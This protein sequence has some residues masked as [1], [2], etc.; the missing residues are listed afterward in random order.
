MKKTCVKRKNKTNNYVKYMNWSVVTGCKTEG[1]SDFLDHFD[2]SVA[3]LKLVGDW[4]WITIMQ[5][6]I[7]SGMVFAERSSEN[8]TWVCMFLFC[9]FLQLM[10]FVEGSS[11]SQMLAVTILL[12]FVWMDI[13]EMAIKN[14]M[15]KYIWSNF[16]KYQKIY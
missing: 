2:G 4:L 1:I 13:L 15:V 5:T 10:V 6:Q 14:V 12:V 7:S 16:V 8:C 3:D 9:Y 11:V